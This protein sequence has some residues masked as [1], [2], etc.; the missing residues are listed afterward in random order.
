MKKKELILILTIAIIIALFFSG[1]SLGKEHTNS[2]KQPYN[3]S[4]RK[5]RKRRL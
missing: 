2:R 5:K 4:R 3:R 1:Y